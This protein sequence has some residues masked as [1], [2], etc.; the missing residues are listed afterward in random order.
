MFN[1]VAAVVFIA[2]V[3]VVDVVVA[4]HSPTYMYYCKQFTY[5]I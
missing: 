4:K 1:V 3:V 5:K 2:V